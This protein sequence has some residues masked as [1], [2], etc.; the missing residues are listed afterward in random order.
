MT[1]PETM[2][3]MR[4]TA[5]D[6][7]SAL[8]LQEI[9]LPDIAGAAL[10][11]VH[12]AGVAFA[13]LLL[14]RGKYQMKPE[15]PFIPGSDIAGIVVRAPEGAPVRVGQRVAG[16]PLT[17]AWAE[18]AA[19]SA[20]M[21]FP[22]PDGMDFAAATSLTVN[23][24]TSYFALMERGQLKPGETVL[25]HGAA[26]G[27]G[28]AAV[29]IAAAGGAHVIAV[30]HGDDKRRTAV[31]SGAAQALEAE[32]PWLEEVRALTDG[33]GVD[34]VYDPV[35]GD[36]FLDSVRSLAPGGRLLVV[37]FAGGSIPS[38]QVNRLLLRNTSVVG[39]AWPEYAR[40]DPEMPQRCAAGLAAMHA[41]GY[42]KPV[43]GA[44]FPLEQAAE[45]LRVI[46]ERR[47]VGKVVLQIRQ[48]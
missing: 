1:L 37:G 25:V 4:V 27:V 36:R 6:G 45:A 24:Q 42:I 17:G 13:D 30:A 19:A 44:V 3:A 22:I 33:R 23:Y 32:G 14:T 26:G 5:L 16:A 35:G 11:E 15:P 40:V 29:Q 18:Y 10:V 31:E 9:P 21:L 41:A 12:A 20:Q 28:S 48:S 8:A 43:V 38:V 34:V 47:A 39:V 7:P 46:E 2:R